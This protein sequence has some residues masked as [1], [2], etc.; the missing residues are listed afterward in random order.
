MYLEQR[1]QDVERVETERMRQQL[2]ATRRL[3]ERLREEELLPTQDEEEE[4]EIKEKEDAGKIERP[5]AKADSKG[6][7][8]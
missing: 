4:E 6:K 5:K 1:F 7:F 8:N 3:V 2:I